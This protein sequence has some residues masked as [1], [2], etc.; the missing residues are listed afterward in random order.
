MGFSRQECWSR[1]PF[2]SPGGLPD[3][4]IKPG[5]P[6]LQEDALPSEPP[7][8][9]NLRVDFGKNLS[10][11]WSLKRERDGEQLRRYDGLNS[12]EF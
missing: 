3:P 7:G 10:C 6:T 5:S 12:S 11:V 1:L 2:P 9:P 8:S 4:G